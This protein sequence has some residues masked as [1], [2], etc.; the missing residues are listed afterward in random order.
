MGPRGS[1]GLCQPTG[2]RCGLGMLACESRAPSAGS[3]L[4]G[5]RASANLLEGG[6]RSL[7]G[8]RGP[9]TSGDWLVGG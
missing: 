5:T 7:L 4:G 8:L 9:E 2:V 6:A 3:G 1:G